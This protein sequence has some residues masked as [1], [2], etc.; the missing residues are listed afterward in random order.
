MSRGK[1]GLPTWLEIS[2]RS[3]SHNVDMFRTAATVDGQCPLMCA[4]VKGNAYGHGL[5]VAS[6][7]FLEAG[8]DW[9][10]IVDLAEARSLRQAGIEAPL[11]GVGYI[12]L[13][14]LGEAID[15]EVRMV[16]YGADAVDAAIA[17]VDRSGGPPARFHIKLETGTNRQ[18]LHL[19]EAVSL[20]RRIVASPGVVLEGVCTHFADI[21]DTTD[22]RF[23]KAQLERFSAGVAA[24]RAVLDEAGLQGTTMMAHAS[25]TAAVTLWPRVCGSLIRFGIGAY[26]MW[27]SKETLVSARQMGR[28]PLQFETA[29]T[30]KT[31]IAQVRDVP[32]GEYVGYGRTFRT[33]RPTRIACLFR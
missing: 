23:A 25:N 9:L 30:W 7:A 22:H 32:V 15:L 33:V 26:G 12:P 17:H 20:A 27:P 14:D 16:V 11:Y 24:I 4:M 21:E 31:R 29:L 1:E 10:G 3:L 19:Q 13:E 28:L 6:Q 18:G 2:T 5:L 8:V